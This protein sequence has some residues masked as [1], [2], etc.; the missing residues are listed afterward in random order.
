MNSQNSL[1]ILNLTLTL[2]AEVFVSTWVST[3]EKQWK[4]IN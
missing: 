3:K 1:K 4:K 2:W